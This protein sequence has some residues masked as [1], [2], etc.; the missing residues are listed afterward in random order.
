MW[1]GLVGSVRGT[2]GSNN[3]ENRAEKGKKGTVLILLAFYYLPEILCCQVSGLVVCV[4]GVADGSLSIGDTVLFATMINQL[5]VPLTFFGS[6]Y[7]QVGWRSI[8]IADMNLTSPPPSLHFP[9]LTSSKGSEGP[10]RHGEHV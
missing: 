10:H 3:E 4:M 6:Y 1:A 8:L 9:F 5:Y 2:D 7:R